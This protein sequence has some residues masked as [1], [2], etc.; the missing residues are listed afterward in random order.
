[1]NTE[2]KSAGYK[3]ILN[4]DGVVRLLFLV[5]FMKRTGHSVE[6]LSAVM[7]YKSR[8]A[9]YHW[10]VNDDV[11]MERLYELFD[12]CGY[13]VTF[14]L[15]PK[16]QKNAG[17]AEVTMDME[18]EEQKFDTRLAFLYNAIRK[19]RISYDKLAEKTGVKSRITVYHWLKGADNCKISQAYK[20]ADALEMR[21]K[22]DIRKKRTL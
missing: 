5:D 22:I 3:S 7:G 19:A 14:S 16:E 18:E 1:M 10:F 13:D 6:S 12:K 17:P 21:M 11:K 15:V 20:I 2:K 8:Q 9:V 4:G